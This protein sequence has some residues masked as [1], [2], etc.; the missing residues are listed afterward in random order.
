LA[1]FIGIKTL[2]KFG[3]GEEKMEEREARIDKAQWG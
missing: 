3:E 2:G 1:I